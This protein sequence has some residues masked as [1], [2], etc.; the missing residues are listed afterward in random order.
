MC[1]SIVLVALFFEK[2]AFQVKY[3]FEERMIA[4]FSQTYD[5]GSMHFINNRF[6]KT[7]KNLVYVR[8]GTFDETPAAVVRSL[9]YKRVPL[10]TKVTVYNLT[11]P[12]ATVYDDEN[13]LTFV[14]PQNISDLEQ[15]NSF[16]ES[17]FLSENWQ[18]NEPIENFLKPVFDCKCWINTQKKQTIFLSKSVKISHHHLA[19]AIFPKLMPWLFEEVPLTADELTMLNT[20]TKASADDFEKAV[21]ALYDDVYISSLTFDDDLKSLVARSRDAF[22]SK[23]KDAVTE[24]RQR[25]E[26]LEERLRES[27]V[28]LREKQLAYSAAELLA[29][30][31]DDTDALKTAIQANRNLESFSFESDSV[32][33]I[34]LRGYLDLF[35][36]DV[37]ESLA[38]N[39]TGFYYCRYESNYTLEER[40]MLLRAIFSDEP[41]FKIA[42]RGIFKFDLAN[43]TIQHIAARNNEIYFNPHLKYYNCF[44]STYKVRIYNAEKDCNVLELISLANASLHSINVSESATFGR[45]VA[46]FFGKYSNY[47]DL[48]MLECTEDGAMYTVD[49]A[50][51]YLKDKK[52]HE[53]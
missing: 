6:E 26:E 28:K 39:K 18:E 2:Q 40:Q 42:V 13:R 47:R 51:N 20:L 25:S 38:N 36:V 41:V 33:K 15:C 5:H 21:E 1:E 12:E 45:L 4:V 10:T 31:E 35:D 30:K 50:I 22:I 8:N 11:A 44:G 48:R 27:Y 9:L 29:E 52:E 37:F 24:A 19:L 3:F 46:D 17:G 43:L 23:A 49:Q 16:I 32:F 14:F 7:F 34:G 53:E